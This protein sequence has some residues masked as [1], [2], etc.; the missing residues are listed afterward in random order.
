MFIPNSYFKKAM[1][2][3]RNI[4]Q[5]HDKRTKFALAHKDEM[6][7]QIEII[8]TRNKMLTTMQSTLISNLNIP[9]PLFTPIC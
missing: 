4:Y 9:I 6:Q 7:S 8:H 3:M 1:K 5:R 2:I